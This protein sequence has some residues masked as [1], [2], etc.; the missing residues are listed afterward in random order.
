MNVRIVLAFALAALVAGV[1]VAADYVALEARLTPAQMHETGL[2]TLSPG[3]LARLNALL[4]DEEAAKPRPVAAPG[5]EPR[6]RVGFAEGLADGPIKTRVVGDVA[7][8]APGTVFTLANGQQWQVLKGEMKLR[9]PLRS[10]EVVLVPGL[11]GRWF[12]QL[13][14]DLPKARVF[15]VD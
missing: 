1:V 4:R 5:V 3:Q 7:S 15:R 11:A 12:L 9:Q 14:E 10:P 2:D 13:D 6:S 8:W